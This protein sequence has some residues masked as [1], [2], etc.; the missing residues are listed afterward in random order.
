MV[1]LGR[2]NA[3]FDKLS[4]RRIYDQAI[5]SLCKILSGLKTNNL[6]YLNR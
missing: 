6:L 4:Q 3:I 1:G 5:D 2:G